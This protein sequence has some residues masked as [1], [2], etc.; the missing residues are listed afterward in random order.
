MSFNGTSVNNVQLCRIMQ[1]ISCTVELA[2]ILLKY[3]G[4]E[5]RKTKG[6]KS[7]VAVM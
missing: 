5:L 7:K 2:D 1:G 4:Y 6:M 3:F